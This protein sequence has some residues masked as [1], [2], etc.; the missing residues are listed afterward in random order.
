MPTKI[1]KAKMRCVR[2]LSMARERFRSRLSSGFFTV[3]AQTDSMNE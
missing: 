3:S 1:G 2:M